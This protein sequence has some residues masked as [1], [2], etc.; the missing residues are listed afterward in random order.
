MARRVDATDE[1]IARHI[2]PDPEG[3]ADRARLAG[4]GVELWALITHLRSVGDDIVQTAADY[5][6]PREAVEVA[7]AYY[8]RHRAVIDAR[9]TLNATFDTGERR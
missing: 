7:L 2:K 1:L 4:S 8:R 6:V 3:R 9:I 5:D